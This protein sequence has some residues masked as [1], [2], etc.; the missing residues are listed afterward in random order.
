MPEPPPYSYSQNFSKSR[1]IELAALIDAAY[2]Q[3][4]D[5]QNNNAWNVPG[6]RTVTPQKNQVDPVDPV[7][8]PKQYQI[9]AQFSA[10]ET[11]GLPTVVPK[12]RIP[13]GFVATAGNDVYVAIR[14]TQTPLEWL[15]DA[16][17]G[18]EPFVPNTAAPGQAW[19]N[20]TKG[21][22]GLYI[23][24]ITD[25][26]AGLKNIQAAG[27]PLNSL[28]VTGHS[29]GAALAHLVA[30]GIKAS[31]NVDPV[32]YTF[33]GPRTG[34]PAFA[35]AF[36][37]Q[38]LQTWRIVN[39]EDIVPIVPISSN[40]L[41]NTSPTSIFLNVLIHGLPAG[42]SHIG[43]PVSVTFDQGR[44]DDNHNLDNLWATL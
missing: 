37:D 14:G 21:F 4:T 25:I 10:V 5:F 7:P 40:Q 24:I 26:I 30:A 20:T 35:Q 38:G 11:W 18:F 39:T 23:Q 31:L 34:D 33:S 22:S 44:V 8:G 2:Q 32:S 29:L 43:Y 15:D 3:L 28:F 16:T 17:V 27:N 1:A 9:E 42:F 36:I 6:P 13:F 41:G 19:G 12:P